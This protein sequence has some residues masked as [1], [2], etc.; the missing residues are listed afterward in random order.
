MK[1]EDLTPEAE[2]IAAAVH[3]L[4]ERDQL[5]FLFTL[6]GVTLVS[7]P[8]SVV[9]AAEYCLPGLKENLEKALDATA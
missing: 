5:R 8:K 4:S 7:S 1:N 3:E 6:L 2:R 9:N